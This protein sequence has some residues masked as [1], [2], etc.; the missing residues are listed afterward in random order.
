MDVLLMYS[1]N[2]FPEGRLPTIEECVEVIQNPG[3]SPKWIKRYLLLRP[4]Y[5]KYIRSMLNLIVQ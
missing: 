5:E 3:S 2:N 1:K 4:E